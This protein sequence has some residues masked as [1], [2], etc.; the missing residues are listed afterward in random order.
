MLPPI[1]LLSG[2]FLPTKY[3]K[4]RRVQKHMS[5]PT[6]PHPGIRAHINEHGITILRL[7]YSADPEKGGGDKIYVPEIKRSISPW[8]YS[9]FKQMTD[10]TLYLKEYEIEAEAALGSLI[11]QLD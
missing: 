9:Q 4:G 3:R 8:A 5:S 6:F 11:Y 1:P 7:H 10:P 2:G